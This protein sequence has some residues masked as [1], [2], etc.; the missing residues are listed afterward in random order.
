[1]TKKETINQIR[2]LLGEAAVN[3][4]KDAASKQHSNSRSEHLD[5]CRSATNLFLALHSYSVTEN[6]AITTNLGKPDDET[7]LKLAQAQRDAGNRIGRIPAPTV[8]G[9]EQV[10]TPNGSDGRNVISTQYTRAIP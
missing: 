5:E 2:D 7:I 9:D 4:A 3:A 10:E 8:E 1:M 6:V